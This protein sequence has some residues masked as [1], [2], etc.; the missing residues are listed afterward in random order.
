MSRRHGD[1]PLV[2]TPTDPVPT[3]EHDVEA[4][5]KGFARTAA[6]VAVLAGRLERLSRL[7]GPGARRAG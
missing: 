5:A 7:A 4:V 2:G 1:W 6:E 3:D